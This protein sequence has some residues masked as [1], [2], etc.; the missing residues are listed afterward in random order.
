MPLPTDLSEY[1]KARYPRERKRSD[2][3]INPAPARRP[4][5]TRP[6]GPIQWLSMASLRNQ[7]MPI[8]TAR[9]PMRLNHCE[10][11]RLSRDCLAPGSDV[12]IELKI[13]A[14]CT[15]SGGAVSICGGV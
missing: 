15:A 12:D 10:P 7:T 14:V 6:A 11:M 9:M 5:R 8:S 13:G 3:A 4:I 2:Q 1:E